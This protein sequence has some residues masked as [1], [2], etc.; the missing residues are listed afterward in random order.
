MAEPLGDLSDTLEDIAYLT[1]SENRVQ[2]LTALAARGTTHGEPPPGCTR[3][4]LEERTDA[5]QPTLSRI[6]TEFEDRGWAE[7]TAEGEYVATPL[8]AHLTDEFTPF[9]R[10]V[11]TLQD[12][13]EMAAILPTTELTIDRRHFSDATVRRPAGPQPTDFR[14]YLADLLQE[15][16]STLYALSQGPGPA[17]PGSY[18]HEL[19]VTGR[20]KYVLINPEHIVD[21]FVDISEARITAQEH[22]KAGAE[23]Y[24][25]D[26][27]I[28]CDLF[29][30]DETVVIG[31]TR[32]DE[33]EAGTAIESQN[34]T[35]RTWALEL[36]D[37]YR[38]KS[39]EL[40]VEALS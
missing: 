36:F 26:E 3:R 31:N 39:E 12:F 35:V 6:L 37:R 25:Y 19:I 18:V 38:E 4:E 28:P 29:I 24:S 13:G 20:L 2:I 40:T 32:V 9:L 15:G 16:S 30:L 8:A 34:E 21:Y 5:S 22:L 14:R 17:T 27:Q 33:V 7:R 11:D 23:Y 1:R 10:S